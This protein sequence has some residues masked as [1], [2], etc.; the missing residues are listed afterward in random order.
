MLKFEQ[1]FK[2][3]GGAYSKVETKEIPLGFFE[4]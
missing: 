3:T 4:K 2:Q 1:R